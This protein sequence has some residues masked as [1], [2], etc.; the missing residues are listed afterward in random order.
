MGSAL[1]FG[2]FAGTTLTFGATSICT[3]NIGSVGATTGTASGATVSTTNALG[4]VKTLIAL[5]K[6]YTCDSSSL[7][8]ALDT[9]SLVI[10]P[11]VS[12]TPSGAFTQAASTS[13][14]FDFGPNPMNAGAPRPQFI[15]RGSTLVAGAS[16]YFIFTDSATASGTPSTYG[17]PLASDIFF[18]FDTI[19]IGASAML[20]G[21]FAAGTITLGASVNVLGRLLASTTITLGASVTIKP[22]AAIISN[23]PALVIADTLTYSIVAAGAVTLGASATTDGVSLASAVVT[24]SGAAGAAAIESLALLTNGDG[25][26]C[27]S[28]GN[29]LPSVLDGQTVSMSISGTAIAH[30][31]PTGVYTLTAGATLTISYKSVPYPLGSSRPQFIIYCTSLTIGAGAKIVLVGTSYIAASP[32]D[33]FFILDGV[34]SVGASAKLAGTFVIGGAVTIGA[35]TNV[36]GRVLSQGAVTLGAS[37]SITTPVA[38]PASAAVV[39]PYLSI[40]TDTI[41][42][43]AYALYAA[44]ALTFGATNIVTAPGTANSGMGSVGITGTA[45]AGAAPVTATYA[46]GSQGTMIDFI[47]RK[48]LA[49][50][51]SMTCPSNVYDPTVNGGTITGGALDGLTLL[52]GVYCSSTGVF[53]MAA[54]TV[55]NFADYASGVAAAGR[56]QF[57]LQASTFTFGASVILQTSGGAAATNAATGAD[58]YFVAD[59]TVTVGASATLM[60]TYL[61][62]TTATLGASV[63]LDGRILARTTI[64]LGASVTV[65]VPASQQSAAAAPLVNTGA[66]LSANQQLT[67][68]L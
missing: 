34:L 38:F 45:L 22:T 1:P 7:P 27:G 48:L 28:K 15:V 18:V 26:V 14:T 33:V 62:G 21:T 68:G 23:P 12:C 10:G 64:T 57:V 8:A 51:Q 19:T 20:S 32:N 25:Q 11:G 37:S 47:S 36:Q 17:P 60:G 50:G 40:D 6:S 52:P 5:A 16:I 44:V 31:T 58:V 30:C 42:N 61:T 13:L 41:K 56:P 24:A 3:G 2:A 49:T 54:S 29:S 4:D 39:V 43:G 63:T 59:T 67:V 66:K 9:A 35:S 46:T 65:T 53:S 55:L